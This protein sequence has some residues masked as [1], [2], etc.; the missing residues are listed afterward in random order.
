MLAAAAADVEAEAAGLVA[1]DAR[2]RQL[3]EESPYV[4]EEARVGGGVAARRAAYG[5]LVYLDDLVDVVDA[6]DAAVWQRR[7][8]R[9]VEVLAEDGLQG[10]VDEGALAGARDARD[11]DEEAQRQVEVDAAEVVA[12]GAL[13]Y[14]MLAALDAA[15]FG[16]LY[17]AAARE[18]VECYAWF[19]LCQHLVGHLAGEEHLA[20]MHAGAGADVDQVV[21]GEHHVAVVLDDDDRVAK[22]AQLLQTVYQAAVVALVEAYARLVEYVEHVG[23]LRAYLRG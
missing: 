6:L 16:Q 5:A 19:V 23:Q 11:A 13:Q 14:Y 7:P 4:V 21:G 9:A 22:V 3:G 10:V 2:R 18:V 12:R 15:P 20:A 1:A 8:Q 17:V